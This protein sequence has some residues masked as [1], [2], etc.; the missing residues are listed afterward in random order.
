MY[1]QIFAIIAPILLIAAVGY[2]WSV[3]KLEFHGR[4]LSSLVVNVG[5]PC[6]ILGAIVQIG[7]PAEELLEMTAITLTGLALF[8]ASNAI[9]LKIYRKPLRPYLGPLSFS[10]TANMGIPVCLLA[11]GQEAM[12]L[13]IVVFMITSIVQFSLGVALVGG[14]NPASAM[15]T[16]PVFYA[17]VL[18]FLVVLFGI[19]MPVAITNTLELLGGIAIPLMLLSLGVSLHS[20]RVNAIGPS[21]VMALVRVGG[22]FALG[23]VVCWLFDLEGIKRAVVLIQAAMPSAVACYML[24]EAYDNHAQEVAGVVVF[25]TIVSFL[26]MPLLLWFI[27]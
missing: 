15:F 16:A 14:R 6:L 2:A 25:S 11:L 27:L 22:G 19:N 5:T 23:L 12:V 26:T 3:A 7:L 1:A 9:F 10:N 21:I 8:F 18:A 24:A 13:A 20:L 4:F 17:T